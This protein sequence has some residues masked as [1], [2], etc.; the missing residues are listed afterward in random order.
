[1]LVFASPNIDNY[2]HYEYDSSRPAVLRY[3]LAVVSHQVC[4]VGIAENMTFN[5]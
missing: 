2:K 4:R 5:F 3:P 1:M